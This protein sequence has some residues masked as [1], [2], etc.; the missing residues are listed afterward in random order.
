M[1]KDVAGDL[2]MDEDE[3]RREHLP[4]A[5]A[6]FCCVS[7]AVYFF[8]AQSP[9]IFRTPSPPPNSTATY[10]TA[11]CTPCA[12]STCRDTFILQFI[13][14]FGYCTIRSAMQFFNRCAFFPLL[15]NWL[16]RL[17]AVA[18]L[19]SGHSALQC[20]WSRQRIMLRLPSPSS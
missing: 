19:L 12:H 15:T 16:T 17:L 20:Q 10:K 2:P 9:T 5:A 11:A 18:Y 6:A 14:H 1:E 7:V 8:A 3:I 4:P 13:C